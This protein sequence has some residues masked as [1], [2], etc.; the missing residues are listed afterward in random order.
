MVFNLKIALEF[1]KLVAGRTSRTHKLVRLRPRVRSRKKE[2]S[3]VLE[4]RERKGV[5][6]SSERGVWLQRTVDFVDIEQVGGRRIDQTVRWVSNFS[7]RVF[8]LVWSACVYE[9]LKNLM[10]YLFVYITLFYVR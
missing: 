7:P 9:S 4:F 5:T 1:I 10:V 3:T 8:G 6:S 2:L